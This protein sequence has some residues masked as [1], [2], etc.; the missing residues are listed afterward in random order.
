MDAT[1]EPQ[2]S[3]QLPA[4]AK[5]YVA[6]RAGFMFPGLG[7]ASPPGGAKVLLL[8]TGGI[9]VFGTW[10]NDGRYQA[11]SPLPRKTDYTVPQ[12]DGA[13]LPRS[14]NLLLLTK[15]GICVVGPWSSDGRYVAWAPTPRR[16][17][18]KEAQLADKREAGHWR[19]AA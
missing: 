10:S 9:A 11:W 12:P 5:N 3:E 18:S 7:E 14:G 15:G 17:R 16:D 1:N 8:T 6:G 4:S 2:S 19:L 13:G